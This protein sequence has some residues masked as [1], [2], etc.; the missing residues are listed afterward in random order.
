MS[1]GRQGGLIE[2][3][4]ASSLRHPRTVLLVAGA[5]AA[6]GAASLW[7]LPVDALPD[8]SEN[9]VIVFAEWPGR[10]PTEVEEQLTHPL[11]AR[12][13]GLAQLEAVRSISEFGFSS[14]SL[15]FE[16]D[17]DFYA[18]RARVVERLEYAASALPPGV[19]PFLSPDATAL[20]QI[21]WYTLDGPGRDPGELRTLQD[22]FVR[23]RLAS[24]AGVAEVASVGGAVREIQIEVDPDRLRA[25]GVSLGQVVAAAGRGTGA[26]GGNVVVEGSTEYVV[27][28]RTAAGTADEVAAAVV[29]A[30]PGVPVLMR[31]LAQVHLGPAPRRSLLEKG[32]GEAVGGVVLMRHGANPLEV[33]RRIEARIGELSLSLPAG[34]RLVPFYERTRLIGAALGTLRRTLLEE[35]AVCVLMVLLVLRHLRSS[36]V[37]VLNALRLAR[38]PVPVQ[39]AVSG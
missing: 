14:I 29:D 33:T 13:Q 39:A 26:S 9:Q 19:E 5:I 10:S 28:G 22:T 2:G 17:A 6:A 24:V 3:V 31:H 27:R 37:V 1:Q 11:T 34:V 36:L 12:L 20:G 38:A 23:P 35:I 16:D 30:R 4:I 15:V 7:R 32:G 21:Y 8:L 18:A 25:H